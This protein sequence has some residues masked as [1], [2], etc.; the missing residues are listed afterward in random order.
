MPSDLLVTIGI[1]TY[2]RA[3]SYFPEALQC[4]LR[5]S[6]GNIE[7]IVSD[8]CSTDSTEALVKSIDDPRIRYF[9]QETN[10]PPTDNF[11]F[12]IGQARGDYFSLLH[13]D[14]SIDEDFIETC[15]RAAS[16]NTEFGLIR[17]GLRWIDTNGNTVSQVRNIADGLSLEEF[18]SAW[19]KGLIPMHLP[20]TLF[21]TRGLKE[22]GGFKSRHQLFND[23]KAEAE[24]AAK[25][26]RLD[27]PDIKASFR[28]HPV[29][30]TTAASIGA[31][32]DDS[33]ELLDVMSDLVSANE[34]DAIR[35]EGARSLVRHNVRLTRQ[36]DSPWT[37]LRSY[38]TIYR[39]FRPPASFLIRNTIYLLKRSVKKN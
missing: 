35:K 32:C 16:G 6:Y 10:I 8:N 39:Y 1:P 14:D 28:H 5:Q 18:F 23:V 38:W 3:D 27:V 34:R 29:R 15:M 9:K 30:H 17:T 33:M 36:I 24:L 4:A 7:I 2:N 31:W 19:F 26:L 12:I 37:Q 20:C 21:N 11:N 13:D 25:Y 22:I